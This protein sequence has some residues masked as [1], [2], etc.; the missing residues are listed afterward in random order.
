MT[1]SA[2]RYKAVFFDAGGTLLHP[3]PSVGE[4]YCEVAGRY[5]CRTDAAKLDQLFRAAWLK[6]DGLSNLASH[7]NEKVEKTWWYSL[8]QDVFSQVGGVRSFEDFFEELYEL[9]GRP[10]VWRLYPGVKPLLASLKQAGIKLGVISNWDSR[11]FQLCEGFGIA[12]Y[13]DFIL[14][15]AVF[16]AAKPSPRIF[17]EAVRRAGIDPAEGLHIGDSLE[18]DVHG[19]R[20]AGL[21]AVL[22]NRHPERHEA[23]GALLEGIPVVTDLTQ[24]VLSGSKGSA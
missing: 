2:D 9:F 3:Y 18:D 1:F 23:H 6:R 13:F 24:I 5:G 22:I 7:S 17:E 8:V 4:I 15:S 12:P 20:R 10:E 14:A 21:D 16:G 11:L 19:A